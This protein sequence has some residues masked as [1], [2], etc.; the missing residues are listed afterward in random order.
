[1]RKQIEAG[2]TLLILAEDVGVPAELFTD[3]VPLL[4]GPQSIFV[5]IA[6]F[7]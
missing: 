7:L 1:M 5:E 3:G 6:R 4:T 2:E